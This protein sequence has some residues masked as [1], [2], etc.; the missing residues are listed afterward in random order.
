MPSLPLDV[1]AEVLVLR[2][3]LGI[4]EAHGE[5]SQSQKR[6]MEGIPRPERGCALRWGQCRRG[7]RMCHQ[8]ERLGICRY[9]L[10]GRQVQHWV[11]SRTGMGRWEA[12]GRLGFWQDPQ[13]PH[14]RGECCFVVPV[15][16]S[17]QSWL[18]HRLGFWEEAQ[19]RV[20]HGGHQCLIHCR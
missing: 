8:Q 9:S 13:G 20:S 5:T 6:E 3:R 2:H 16:T 19:S 17:N 15:V 18:P 4:V 7:I 10:Q 11:S 12:L 1:A 14:A